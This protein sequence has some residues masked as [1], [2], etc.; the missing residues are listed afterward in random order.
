MDFFEK[1]INKT[2]YSC[3]GIY[4]IYC[5]ITQNGFF[6]ES[7]NIYESLLE[8][9]SELS[10]GRFENQELQEEF[11]VFGEDCFRFDPFCWDEKYSDP[12]LRKK[13]VEELSSLYED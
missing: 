7:D 12:F 6:G 3:P 8:V 9:Y 5:V 13:K 1:K 2:L 11:D 10:E 4:E